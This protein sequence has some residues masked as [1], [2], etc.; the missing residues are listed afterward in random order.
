ME[1]LCVCV[2]VCVSVEASTQV[3]SFTGPCEVKY[4]VV[5]VRDPFPLIKFNRQSLGLV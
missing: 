1:A 2:F 3:F 5:L 4:R